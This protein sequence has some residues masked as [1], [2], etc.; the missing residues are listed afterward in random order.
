MRKLSLLSRSCL[1]LGLGGH[2]V[3]IGGV[4]D[5]M[6]DCFPARCEE[7]V[8]LLSIAKL[9]QI[10]ALIIIKSVSRGR[11]LPRRLCVD[12]L[13][14]RSCAGGAGIPRL[15]PRRTRRGRG[16]I[17]VRVSIANTTVVEANIEFH[18]GHLS[19]AGAQTRPCL[20]SRILGN[21][22]RGCSWLFDREDDTP[23]LIA[24]TS[25]T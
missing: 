19:A 21:F 9:I 18:P 23:L 4:H 14:Q 6:H 12:D 7:H 15:A 5:Q 25:I 17:E 20:V 24:S 8:H 13:F 10:S 1:Q 2:G 3:R 22:I 11:H 16:E